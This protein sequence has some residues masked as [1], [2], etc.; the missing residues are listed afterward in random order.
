MNAN[1]LFQI[2]VL[3]IPPKAAPEAPRSNGQGCRV[4]TITINHSAIGVAPVGLERGVAARHEASQMRNTSED[5]R[6]R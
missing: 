2:P 3:V 4:I 5:S 6:G 1:A